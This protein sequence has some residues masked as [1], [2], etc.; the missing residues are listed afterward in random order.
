MSTTLH[1]WF[2]GMG[3]SRLTFG[4]HNVGDAHVLLLGRFLQG[5]APADGSAHHGAALSVDG[6]VGGWCGVVV[7]ELGG[8]KEHWEEGPQML[9]FHG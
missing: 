5:L 8:A 6:W 9:L 2:G 1:G 4:R 7:K 3:V